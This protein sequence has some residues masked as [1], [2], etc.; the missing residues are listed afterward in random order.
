MAKQ[1]ASNVFVYILNRTSNILGSRIRIRSTLK[2]ETV[3]A[4]NMPVAMEIYN[5]SCGGTPR[6]RG[7]I[8]PVFQIR[9]TGSGSASMPQFELEN[10]HIFLWQ[11]G[12]LTTTLH[13]FNN[14]IQQ[15]AELDVST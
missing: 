3:E 13:P 8:F 9:I 5:W 14:F 10:Y 7:R 11:A 4:H 6:S 12:A 2:A 1:K 15:C